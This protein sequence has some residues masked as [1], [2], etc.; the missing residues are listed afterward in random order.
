M[1]RLSLRSFREGNHR[2][3]ERKTRFRK[4]R[5]KHVNLREQGI[6]LLPDGQEFIAHAVF[7]GTYVLYTP[8]AWEVF[9]LHMYESNHSGRLLQHGQLTY[10]RVEDLTDTARTAH[11][12]SRG[13]AALASFIG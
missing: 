2:R 8:G 5:M 4:K 1:P 6:Y 11:S 7:R 3:F 13:T 9:G 10:W 12:R